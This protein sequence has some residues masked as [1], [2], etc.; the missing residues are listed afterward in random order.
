M[1]M[2]Q[3]AG[4]FVFVWAIPLSSLAFPL[5]S[6]NPGEIDWF[7]QFIW[8]MLA[9]IGGIAKALHG[10]INENL[11][12]IRWERV[13]AQAIISGF[14]GYTLAHIIFRLD[15][16]WALVSAGIGG[17]MGTQAID[18]AII[19]IKKSVDKWLK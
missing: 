7:Y 14:S 9:V 3:E 15:P 1:I 18:W 13:M 2:K 8:L 19:I 10:Y 11:D 6:T 5:S 12:K 17:Y 4:Q 16:N